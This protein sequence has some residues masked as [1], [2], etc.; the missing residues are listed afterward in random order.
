VSQLPPPDRA[1]WGWVAWLIPL[2]IYTVMGAIA[3]QANHWAAINFAML[4]V[5][6]GAA[7]AAHEAGHAIAAR[8]LGFDVHW[9][10]VGNGPRLATFTLGRTRIALSLLPFCGAVLATTRRRERFRQRMQVFIAAGPWINVVSIVVGIW[11]ARPSVHLIFVEHS[12]WACFAAANIF[13]LRQTAA[14]GRT[15]GVLT[16]VDLLQ[17]V[18][19]ASEAQLDEM[20]RAQRID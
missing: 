1:H 16:D 7:V 10:V 6:W 17:R 19:T 15:D 12:F 3:G 9:A 13:A 20:F 5:L 11:L 2:A 14:A 18:A 8:L 4:I